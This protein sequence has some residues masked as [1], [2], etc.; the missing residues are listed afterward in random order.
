MGSKEKIPQSISA[1]A[2]TIETSTGSS[3]LIYQKIF[4][5][6]FSPFLNS[7]FFSFF[8]F[9]PPPLSFFTFLNLFMGDGGSLTCGYLLESLRR[10]N[11]NLVLHLFVGI[12]ILFFFPS[13]TFHGF[14]YI[15]T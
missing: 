8:A 6:L 10:V 3:G 15:N 14:F 9:F 12:V 11:V 5:P 1:L 2:R 13:Y 4:S 7:L